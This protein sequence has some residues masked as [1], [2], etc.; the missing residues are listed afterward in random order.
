MIR[1]IISANAAEGY[2]RESLLLHKLIK[3]PNKVLG[4]LQSKGLSMLSANGGRLLFA[5]G[6]AIMADSEQNL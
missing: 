3:I 5:D 4:I 2:L 6:T 1:R